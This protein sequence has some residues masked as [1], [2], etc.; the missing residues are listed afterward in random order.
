MCISKESNKKNEKERKK[1]QHCIA[2]NGGGVF[3]GEVLDS[4]F[5]CIVVSD[6]AAYLLI[7][8]LR[9]QYFHK[10]SKP[11]SLSAP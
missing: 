3:A 9:F 4:P 6:R 8:Y 5:V 2:G 11:H 10:R 1:H 7:S